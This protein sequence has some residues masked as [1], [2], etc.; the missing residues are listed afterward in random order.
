MTMEST[1]SLP[2]PG[3]EKIRSDDHDPTEEEA[4][5]S[6]PAC[7]SGPGRKRS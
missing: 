3:L 1:A 5:E 2:I 4:Q 7:G 6:T